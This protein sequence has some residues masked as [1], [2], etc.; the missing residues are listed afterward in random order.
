[1]VVAACGAL[2]AQVSTQQGN[3]DRKHQE[4]RCERQAEVEEKA[5]GWPCPASEDLQT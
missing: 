1:M 3:H 2:P 5:G 4:G